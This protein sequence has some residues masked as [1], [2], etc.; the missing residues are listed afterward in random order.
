VH[1]PT[2][3]DRLLPVGAGP[4]S[5]SAPITEI[6]DGAF[7]VSSDAHVVVDADGLVVMANAHARALFALAPTDVGRPLK[8]LE[9]SYRPADLRSNLELA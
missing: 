4:D 2:L 6:R 8:D 3:R 1:K 5:A 9:L 7:E